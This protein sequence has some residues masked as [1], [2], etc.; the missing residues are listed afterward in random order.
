MHQSTG[1]G[2]LRGLFSWI[3]TPEYGDAS[4]NR[5][6]GDFISRAALEAALI[7]LLDREE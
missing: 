2:S 4:F 6:V 3:L 1:L 5:N 7:G